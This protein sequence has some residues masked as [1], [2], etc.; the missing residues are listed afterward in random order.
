MPEP[1]SVDIA[2]EVR[3]HEVLMAFGDRQ[4]RVRGLDKNLSY[5]LLRVNILAAREPAFHVDTLDLYS[6]KHRTA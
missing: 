1:A 3:E 4:Y 5:D 6:A 2:A